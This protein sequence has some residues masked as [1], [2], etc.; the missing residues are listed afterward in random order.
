MG[1]IT[2]RRKVG[3]HTSEENR[4]YLL[5]QA[6]SQERFNSITREHWGS[7]NSLHWVLDMVFNEDQS[8]NRKDNCPDNLAQLAQLE[9]DLAPLEPSKG[10]MR[11]K[12]KRAGG[13]D[14][15]LDLI[16]CQFTKNQM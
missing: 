3:D 9:L 4:Y 12:L 6:F 7:E 13:D 1:K 2:T 11:G 8:R 5:S 10:S 16:L 15:D 14:D